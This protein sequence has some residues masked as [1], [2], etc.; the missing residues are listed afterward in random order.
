MIAPELDQPLFQFV[1]AM[2]VCLVKT[3]L[4]GPMVAYI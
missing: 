2:D 3:L 1:N 4:H